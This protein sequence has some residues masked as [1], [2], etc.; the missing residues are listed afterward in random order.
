IIKNLKEFTLLGRPV[1]VGVSR[2]AFI[3]KILGDVPPSERLEGTASA[4]AISIFNG[5]NIIRVHD[6]KEMAKVAKV[7]DAI[8]RCKI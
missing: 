6:V 5:A 3:G 1:A 7:A 2:K 4:V 8:K